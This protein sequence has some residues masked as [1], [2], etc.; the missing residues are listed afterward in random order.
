MSE[1]VHLHCH[2]EY[3]LLDG[4][5]R[6]RD[7]CAKAK[8]CG[9]PAAAITDHGNLFGAGHFYLGCKE[10]GIKPIIGCEAYVCRDHRDKESERARLRHHLVLLAQNRAGYGNL[11]KLV[12]R[13]FL[14][15]FY[16]RPRMD[17]AMLR[18]H[19]EGLIALSACIAGEIP[20]AAL[21]GD[22]DGAARLAREYADIFPDRF[23]LELQSNGL[24]E[25][26]I[27]NE[28]LLE[29]AEHAKLPI[30]A[31][32]DCHYLNADDVEAHD[33]L[34]CIQTQA[35]VDDKER[36]RFETKELYYKTVEEMEKD[37]G[38][39][40]GALEN[41][42]RVTEQCGLELRFDRHIFPVYALPEGVTPEAEFRRLAEEGL[43]RRLERH[44]ARETLD[45]ALYRERL[46]RELR[47][48]TEMR[49]ADYFLIV[50]DF[51]NRA[52][53]R[54]IPVGPGRGSA[55]G[56]LVAWALR[57]TNL[58]PIP[59][60]LLFERFLNSERVSLPDIDVDFCERRRPEVIRYM[61]EKYGENA[62]AQ[63][64]TFGTMKARA[65]VRDVG[66]ALGFSVAE[67][68]RIAK[69]VPWDLN[70]TV[71][72]ALDAEPELAAL[73][74]QDARVRRLLDISQRLEGLVRHASTHAAGLVVADRPMW[75]YLPLY[76][77]KSDEAACEG[78]LV[79][80]FDMKMVE[81]TGLVKFDFLGL[82][83]M[84][85]IQDTLD[86]VRKQGRVPPDPDAFPLDD[87][88]VYELYARGDTDG[89]FQVESAGMRRYLRK[90]KPSRFED[91]IAMLA[92]YRPGTLKGEIT[93]ETGA[94]MN[95]VDLFIMRKNGELPVHYPLRELENCLRDTYGV[96]VYQEQVMEI[97]R[98]VAGYSL[99]QAD[100]LR[101]AMGK[102]DRTAMAGERSRFVDGARK[103]GI[104][105]DKADEI[106][107][108]VEKFAEYGFNKSHSAAYALISYQTA[109]LKTHFG[110]EFMAALLTSEAGNQDKLLKYVS[111]CKDM[112]I[113]VLPPSVNRSANAFAVHEGS[114][115]FG[116][117][118]V[119]NVGSEAVKAITE[120]REKG[121]EF[122]SLLDLAQR[123]SLRKVTKRVLE[124]LIKSG[125]C[126]CFNAPRAALL[127]GLDLVTARAQKR[128]KEKASRQGSLLS[129]S[130]AAPAEARGGLG[131]ACPE[132]AV[133]EMDEG[134][135]LRLEKE[136]LGL[137]LSSHPLQPY[138]RETERL[139]LTPL[140]E[141]RGMTP[142]R[143]SE[144]RCAALVTDIREVNTR[145]GRMAFVQ[146]EDLTARAE[147]LFF[148]RAYEDSRELLKGDAPL[149]IAF[150]V[151]PDGRG[152]SAAPE[153]E[154]DDDGALPIKLV[155]QRARLLSEACADGAPRRRR[156]RARGEA[157]SPPEAPETGGEGSGDAPLIIEIPANRLDPENVRALARIL[158]GHPGTAEVLAE[159]CIDDH[160][161]TLLF[162]PKI[163]VRTGPELSGEI[164]EWAR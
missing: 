45:T 88:P 63:I 2:T 91:L 29:L 127:A 16:S 65:V 59:Y 77:G 38:R 125:A 131:L 112:G 104:G 138:L 4:A 147:L 61:A 79:S 56:S 130:S 39:L 47:V 87:A 42:L 10:F 41:T 75:E 22:M 116:L 35:R 25:Q 122:A 95:M 99:G 53:D 137:F 107:S 14:D 103:K 58:D 136:T 149:E 154:E 133:E 141:A 23:Y 159:V 144:L 84:T 28:R 160:R 67:T 68:D 62:V 163:R 157:P 143:D 86:A 81:K 120:A 43:E 89:V 82:R 49:F 109:Y 117:G 6:I 13:S 94:K 83:T 102:K 34:L 121:G 72:K 40:P 158:D 55:A 151:R 71:Q 66:R 115:L 123:V 148:P 100:L 18:E 3:S 12:T 70:M 111:A 73:H 126:D 119:K 101:R 105:E 110:A 51:I 69:L 54:G 156:R 1:F 24:K 106:F 21:K 74:E 118:A 140:E 15:G 98:I 30:V 146:V 152:D 9:M 162:A 17:K 60:K 150:S 113:A 128:A 80:Q 64:T 26:E 153:S 27:V 19:S 76:R 164:R 85:V 48:I 46:E 8:D 134:E 155:G 37:F 93:T 20:D 33:I 108:L 78:M 96:M 52:K 31:T 114:V 50:Q 90:L 124:A 11:L 161:C 142:G 139:D 145:K 97:G 36:M 32:N 92:L 129:A 135:R 5:I 132:E 57:I 7:L 44:P